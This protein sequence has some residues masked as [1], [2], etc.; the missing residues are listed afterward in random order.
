MEK[1]E[2]IKHIT[3]FVN[4]LSQ[5]AQEEE[6][7]ENTEKEEVDEKPK[8][9]EQTEEDVVTEKGEVEEEQTAPQQEEVYVDIDNLVYKDT[10]EA[11]LDARLESLLARLDATDKK[12]GDITDKFIGTDIGSKETP[13]GPANDVTMGETFESYSAKFMN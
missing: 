4:G 8:Q 6:K 7:V 5:P 9:V 10:L 1:E 13:K 2:L 12:V 3:E 11:M